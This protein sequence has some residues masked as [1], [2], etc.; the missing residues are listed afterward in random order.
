M[1]QAVVKH[2]GGFLGILS[3]VM[4]NPSFRE[5]FDS[6]FNTWDDVKAVFMLMKVYQ[7][8][9]RKLKEKNVEISS[10]QM[11]F[12]VQSAFSD[13]K[14]RRLITNDMNEFTEKNVDFDSG[15]FGELV[16]T[17]LN[18]NMI[19][20]KAEERRR[21]EELYGL[22]MIRNAEEKLLRKEFDKSK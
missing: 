12:I 22:K 1:E 14:F 13:G 21:N 5:L 3:D 19:A 17:I 4:R 18:K 6:Y 10:D 8:I 2:S 15:S 9:D 16:D 7:I 11:V 20:N